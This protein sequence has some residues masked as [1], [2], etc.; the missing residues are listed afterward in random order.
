MVG[1]PS[2]DAMW[3]LLSNA[4]KNGFEEIK[5]LWTDGDQYHLLAREFL[6]C[7]PVTCLSVYRGRFQRRR[8]II[9]SWC[10]SSE[11]TSGMVL[12]KTFPEYRRHRCPSGP[13][14]TTAMLL[15]ALWP[16]LLRLVLFPHIWKR[17]ACGQWKGPPWDGRLLSAA[18]SQRQGLPAATWHHIPP[19]CVAPQDLKST[20]SGWSFSYILMGL[21]FKSTPGNLPQSF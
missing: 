8:H 19:V 5:V 15:E 18:S 17:G 6:Q 16:S 20:R 10:L 3:S 2:C 1:N 4:R 13:T 12:S 9:S 11:I 21:L 14:S 7:L